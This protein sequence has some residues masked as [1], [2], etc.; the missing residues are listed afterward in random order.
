MFIQNTNELELYSSCEICLPVNTVMDIGNHTS[1]L[2]SLTKLT[3]DII[4]L[5]TF[6]LLWEN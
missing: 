6:N 2:K 3:L 1:K 5:Y 4:H